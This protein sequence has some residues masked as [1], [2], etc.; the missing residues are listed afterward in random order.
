MQL[1]MNTLALIFTAG[2]PD[3]FGRTSPLTVYGRTTEGYSRVV[4]RNVRPRV[5]A[6]QKVFDMAEGWGM[7]NIHAGYDLCG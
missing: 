1:D 6:V 4:T 2:Q 7:T 3:E 5:E